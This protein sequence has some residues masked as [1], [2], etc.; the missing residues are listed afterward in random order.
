MT[1]S[2][3]LEELVHLISGMGRKAIIEQLR[4]YRASFP[5]DFTPQYLEQQSLDRLQH[6]LL[7][8]CLQQKRLPEFAAS[9]AA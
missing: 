8:L 3:Q 5:V 4:N 7:A 2:D 1:K 9:E 6:L